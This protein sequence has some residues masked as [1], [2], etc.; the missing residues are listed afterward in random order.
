MKK[1]ACSF[2][3]MMIMAGFIHASGQSES[4]MKAWT[5]YM[6]PGDMHKMLEKSNGTWNTKV[7]MWMAPGAEP[8]MSEGTTINEM[9][10]GGRYQKST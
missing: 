5:D 7:T 8:M 9:I 6:T 10:M 4:E 2:F 1:I 3:I